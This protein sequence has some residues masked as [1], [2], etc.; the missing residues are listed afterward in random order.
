MPQVSG[1][2]MLTPRSV[3]STPR[4]LSSLGAAARTPRTDTAPAA[5]GAG[6]G[7]LHE[8]TKRSHTAA[9]ASRGFEGSKLLS[10]DWIRAIKATELLQI[11]SHVQNLATKTSQKRDKAEEALHQAAHHLHLVAQLEEHAEHTRTHDAA[12]SKEALEQAEEH[13]RIA[14]Q[15]QEKA[16]NLNLKAKH[17]F[18]RTDTEIKREQEE[19]EE[20]RQMEIAVQSTVEQMQALQRE[21]ERQ[22]QQLSRIKPDKDRKQAFAIDRR[23]VILNSAPSLSFEKPGWP[24]LGRT[25]KLSLHS[26]KMA[27][28]KVAAEGVMSTLDPSSKPRYARTARF[29][30][31]PSLKGVPP[32]IEVLEAF[33]QTVLGVPNT[34]TLQQFATTKGKVEGVTRQILI[35]IHTVRQKRENGGSGKTGDREADAANIRSGAAALNKSLF[36]LREALAESRNMHNMFNETPKYAIGM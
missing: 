16:A 32:T 11:A 28:A 6:L 2:R 1:H 22:T 29:A 3:A 23:V 13:M 7:D 27:D 36:V 19:K 18:R 34:S 17:K 9:G 21:K 30:K 5:P 14:V 25:K 12:G 10:K 20:Q 8:E 35:A 24:K 4:R 26:M 15:L 31:A 33:G